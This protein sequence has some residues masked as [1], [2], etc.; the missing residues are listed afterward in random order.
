MAEDKNTK[1]STS[2]NRTSNAKIGNQ[3]NF[4]ASEA[5]K[6]LRTNLMFSFSDTECKVIGV[7]SSVKAEGKST[8]S[9]NLSYTLGEQ[10]YR[11]LLIEGDMRMPGIS[12]QL[13]INPI[14][15]MSNLLS[16]MTNKIADV[17]HQK[18]FDNVDYIPAG[19]S[20]PNPAELLGSNRMQ[21]TLDG[22]KK[23]YDYIIIDLAP[24]TVVSDPLVASKYLKGMI[25]VVRHEM[26][27][28]KNIAEAVRLLK[29]SNV[30]ILGFVYNAYSGNSGSYSKKYYKKYGYG[31]G[32]GDERKKTKNIE[33]KVEKNKQ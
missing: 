30:R 13:G 22:L 5:Y 8:T 11:V 14:P 15:G 3:M 12:T 23:I 4:A 1:T 10:G 29:F 21:A 19:E 32:Y 17:L 26:A 31:Y 9:M 25:L 28:Q 18:I 6:M 16:G 27:E 33:G 24:V 2:S 7:T 20:V